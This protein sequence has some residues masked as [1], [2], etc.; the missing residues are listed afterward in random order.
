MINL[1][2]GLI[3]HREGNCLWFMVYNLPSDIWYLVSG[4]LLSVIWYLVIC[5]QWYHL[6]YIIDYGAMLYGI[7]LTMVLCYLQN[8]TIYSTILSMIL[9]HLQHNTVYGTLPSPVRYST[10]KATLKQQYSTKFQTQLSLHISCLSYPPSLFFPLLKSLRWWLRINHFMSCTKK[11]KENFES[12]YVFL[13]GKR[14]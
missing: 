6:R 13:R 12:P 14:V 8:S 2:N 10:T 9:Y 5:H 3:K 4:I 11:M 7:L 1:T